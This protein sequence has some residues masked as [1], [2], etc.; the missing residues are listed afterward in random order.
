MEGKILIN[1]KR[2]TVK[3]CMPSLR[4]ARSILGRCPM[5]ESFVLTG[6]SQKLRPESNFFEIIR[7]GK[8]DFTLFRRIYFGCLRLIRNFLKEKG[9][10]S[11]LNASGSWM[12]LCSKCQKWIVRGRSDKQAF[13]LLREGCSGFLG[14]IRNFLKGRDSI[15]VLNASGSWVSLWQR[16]MRVRFGKQ[17]FAF[18]RAVYLNFSRLIRNFLN[19][20]DSIRVLNALGRRVLL[21][22]SKICNCLKVRYT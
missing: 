9:R 13:A 16:T 6:I 7:S 10:N 5:I 18:S 22:L 2:L 11:L 12:S 3:S 17:G 1:K 21:P 19:G 8:Q 4:S 14:L 15:R 20:R